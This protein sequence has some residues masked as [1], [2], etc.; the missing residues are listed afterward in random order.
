[1]GVSLYNFV[2]FFIQLDI[3]DRYSPK[4]ELLLVAN[5]KRQNFHALHLSRMEVP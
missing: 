2:H 4:Q 1:L 3:S 5:A